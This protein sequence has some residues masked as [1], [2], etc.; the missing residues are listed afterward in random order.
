MSVPPNLIYRLIPTK[1][2]ASYF[3]DI[4]KLFLKFICRSQRPRIAN[5]ILKEKNKAGRLM[6]PDFKIYHNASVIKMVWY[7]QKNGE[8]DH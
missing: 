8:V 3:V 7:W 6:P 5:T 4:N 2:P 1:I